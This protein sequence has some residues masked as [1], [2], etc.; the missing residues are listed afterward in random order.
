[1]PAIKS[2]YLN[3]IRGDVNNTDVSNSISENDNIISI[4]EPYLN[5]WPNNDDPWGDNPPSPKIVRSCS[6]PGL[7][8]NLKPVVEQS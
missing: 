5:F 1:M 3:N 4:I 6:Q 7:H 2:N 8:S